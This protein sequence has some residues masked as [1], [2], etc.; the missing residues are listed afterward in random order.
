MN[1]KTPSTDETPNESVEAT[2]VA[3][4]QP[5]TPQGQET[6][7]APEPDAQEPTEGEKV[8]DE[9]TTGNK[10][11]AKYRRR[12]R[13][14]ETER[15][16]LRGQ[17]EEMQRGEVERIAV[18]R[19]RLRNAAIVWQSA[20]LSE[21]LAEGGAVD[22]DKVL[23]VV[24][25]VAAEYGLARVPLGNHAPNEGRNPGKPRPTNGMAAVISGQE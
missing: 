19:G 22:G 17:L 14:T 5:E 6:P 23:R 20:E 11:A 10:E 3:P 2:Q 16:Q 7:E 12:L 18:E 8:E 25:N 9:P 21:L 1:K 24:E 15:D 4:T 13:D